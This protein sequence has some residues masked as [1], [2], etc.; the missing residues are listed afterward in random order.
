AVR[1]RAEGLPAQSL[2]WGLWEETS[3][4]TATLGESGRDRLDRGGL[5]AL[6]TEEGLALFDRSLALDAPH[7]VPVRLDLSRARAGDRQVAPLLRALVRTPARRTTGTP[8]GRDWRAQYEGTPEDGRESMLVDLVRAQVA[9]VLGHSGTDAVRVDRGFKDLGFDSLTAVELRNRLNELTGTRL[10]ATLVFDYPTPAALGARLHGLLDGTAA[11]QHSAVAR[12]V[13]DDEPIAIVGMSCR[14]PGHVDSPEELWQLLADGGEGITG[15]PKDRGWA[16][17]SF[18][19]PTGER[20][21]TS[22]VDQGGFLHDAADFDASFFG[23]SPREAVTMDPQHRMLLELS[24]EAIE[25]AGVDPTE[26]RGSRTGVFSGLMYHEYAARL[27]S[28]PEDVAGFL[29]NGNAGSVATGRVSYTLGFEGPAV[30]VDTACSSS[31]VALDMAVSALQRAECDLA[32]AGGVTVMSTPTIFAE[33]TRQRG[34]AHDGR[35]KA[36]SDTADGMGVAEGAGVVLV[37]RLSDARRNGHRV[38]AVI[39]GSA[40]N[41]D[42]ASNGLTAPNGP[43]QQRVIRSALDNAGLAASDVD[44]VE[45][46]GTGTSLGDPIEAQA[47]LATYGQDRPEGRPLLLGSVKSNIG[48]TQA[49]AGIAGVM[50]MVLAL[51]HGTVPRTLHAERPSEHVDWTAGAVELVTDA[52]AWP[53]TGRPRRGAVS[54]FGISGTNAHVILEQAPEAEPERSAERPEPV[55]TAAEGA[56]LPWLV[57]AKSAAALRAQAEQLRAFAVAGAAPAATAAALIGGRTA[58]DERAVVLAADPAGFAE[59]LAGLARQDAEVPGLVSGTVRPGANVAFVFP[60]QGA[61]WTG[62]ALGLMESSPV[63]AG[64]LRECADVLAPHADWNLLEVLG[65]KQALERVDVVQPALWAVMVSLAKVWQHCGITPSVVVGHS[66]GEIAAACV[67]GALSL[68]DGA[69]LVAL[70]SRVIAEELAGRGGMASL[71]VPSDEAQALIDRYTNPDGATE[72]ATGVVVAAVNGPGAVVVAGDEGPLQQLLDGC[73]ADGIRARRIPVTYPSHAPQVELIKD[74]LI[75]E[76]G[77]ISPARPQVT[78]RSTVTGED[79]RDREADAD[80]WYRNLRRPVRFAE[81]VADLMES[82]IDTFVEISPH[83]VTT[84]ALEDAAL[85]ADGRE[86]VVTGTLRRDED[87]RTALLRNAAALWTRGLGVDWTALTPAPAE[88]ADTV[89]LPTYAFQRERYWLDAPADSGNPGGVGQEA[90]GHPVLAA[91]VVPAGTDSILFTGR[92]TTP[93]AASPTEHTVLDTP[94]LPGSALLDWALYAADRLGLPGV[95]HLEQHQALL[96]APDEAVRVQ[97]MAAAPDESGHR[98]VTVHTQPDGDATAEWILHATA[99][100]HP[101]A[102][103][104]DEAY[105]R[106]A[107]TWPPADATP[108]DTAGLYGEL[109]A[110]EQQFG[111]ALQGLRGAWRT[112]DDI[113]AEIELLEQ[114]VEGLTPRAA[115]LE[116][117]CHAWRLADEGGPGTAGA[118]HPTVWRGVRVRAGGLDTATGRDAVDDARIVRVLLSPADGGALRVRATDADGIPLLSVDQVELRPVTTALLRSAGAGAARSLYEVSWERRA[119]DELAQT[120]RSILWDDTRS[121]EEIEAAVADGV[122]LVLLDA[123]AFDA[124]GRRESDG[125]HLP[126]RVREAVTA[127]LARAKQWL[128]D[129][130]LADAR[131]A[132][133]THGAVAVSGTGPVDLTQAAVRGFLRSVQSEHPGRFVLVDSDGGAVG[134]PV[135]VLAAA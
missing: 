16:L 126:E 10:P 103:E 95:A 93:A 114:A 84:A 122:R 77:H 83:P 48:H 91:A 52:V 65:D 22:L 36:F 30:T 119:F 130:A 133:V 75:K 107:G 2:S 26:L 56:V 47:L 13:A 70:R 29:S 12:V 32:L 79:V 42:G 60:G 131:L 92:L 96:L 55:L 25:R 67:A 110:A 94:V 4:L 90:T 111:T 38:L 15:F 33:F 98:R 108:A 87:E 129:E 109:F 99:E 57:S 123:A 59:G 58:F 97:V 39:K 64:A 124:H 115:L 66:Q 5:Q 81:V 21:G 54:S 74:R 100:L 128:A 80:Y 102:E 117:V 127:T 28:V 82:G 88:R 50:K 43:S 6:G 23:I 3:E 135:S 120:P 85:Q 61:Q 24:W 113:Y 134:V 71:T 14:F 37:E 27:R 78:W 116:S 41:Q 101:G 132:V 125:E 1:R 51:R 49:A 19:D 86:V 8:V 112:G 17:D 104:S 20:P 72:P 73:E 121:A 18:F 31:L 62:M 53:E 44:V 35:C 68:A 34:L 46:H 63:F 69:R 89:D 106:L 9:S 118:L 11:R 7:L 105:A 40:V 45:A 76:L